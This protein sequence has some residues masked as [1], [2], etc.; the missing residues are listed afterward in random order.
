MTTFDE[1]LKNNTYISHIYIITYLKKSGSHFFIQHLISQLPP[2]N[3]NIIF[4]NDTSQNIFNTEITDSLLYQSIYYNILI[5]NRLIKTNNNI[6]KCFYLIFSLEDKTI[7]EINTFL[8]IIIASNIQYTHIY[9]TRDIISI[10]TSRLD[11]IFSK[12]YF[13]NFNTI[14]DYN[15]N[16]KHKKYI[17]NKIVYVKEQLSIPNKFNID[18]DKLYKKIILLKKYCIKY[19]KYINIINNVF[20]QLLTMIPDKSTISLYSDYLKYFDKYYTF[21][22][23]KF[24]MNDS[25]ALNN[26]YL[27]SF[28]QKLI[29]NKDIDIKLLHMVSSNIPIFGFAYKIFDYY[30]PTYIEQYKI[31]S[32]DNK[33]IQSILIRLFKYENIKIIQSLCKKKKIMKPYLL[34]KKSFHTNITICSHI[35]N[36]MYTNINN[37]NISN[38]NNISDINYNTTL[39][40]LLKAN[41]KTIKHIYIIIALRF[42]ST[43]YLLQHLICQLPYSKNNKNILYLNNCSHYSLNGKIN[44]IDMY[45]SLFKHPTIN[46]R[47]IISYEEIKK[48]DYIILF[49]EEKQ[50]NHIDKIYELLNTTNI[51]D[52]KCFGIRDYINILCLRFEFCIN[53]IKK[54]ILD[55]PTYNAS[56]QYIT[57]LQFIED[58]KIKLLKPTINYNKIFTLLIDYVE[59]YSLHYS[60]F[61]SYVKHDYLNQLVILNVNINRFFLYSEYIEYINNNPNTIVFDYNIYLFDNNYVI[62]ILHKLHIKKIDN[63]MFNIV[64]SIIPQDNDTLSDMLMRITTY[65]SIK[66]FKDIY[67]NP[68][69]KY[70]DYFID[71]VKQ[72][73][74]DKNKNK[75]KNKKKYINDIVNHNKKFKLNFKFMKE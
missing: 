70:F 62:D 74:K 46:E 72:L 63:N 60:Y 22:Y 34:F 71:N 1:L 65:Q 7:E 40:E 66:A 28:L 6:D 39:I 59:F 50:F 13:E 26:V 58:I 53:V 69:G 56:P 49:V 14:L 44:N 18:Y 5:D 21:D 42:S 11:Y 55:K 36:I 37:N 73:Y 68:V 16:Q 48:V 35:N 27:L 38:I 19:K 45:R 67:N 31:N 52:T 32:L 17:T 25:N 51:P 41:N 64:K 24:I 75:N 15:N 10:I 61:V 54:A 4:I 2:H 3:E 29:P 12:I 47:L 30:T 20:I 33:I 57:L 9:V 8:K 43:E 23:N